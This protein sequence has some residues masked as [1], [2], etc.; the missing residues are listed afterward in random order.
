MSKKKRP[1]FP[2]VTLLEGNTW[3]NLQ[4]QLCHYCIYGRE[5]KIFTNYTQTI[6]CMYFYKSE[7][8][9]VKL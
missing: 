4:Q 5:K 7:W 2:A 8:V 9:P 6:S 3:T 1:T